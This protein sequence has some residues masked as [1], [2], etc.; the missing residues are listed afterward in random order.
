MSEIGELLAAALADPARRRELGGELRKLNRMWVEYDDAVA[1]FVL[2]ADAEP[3]ELCVLLV[4]LNWRPSLFGEAV[5]AA[6]GVDARQ[7]AVLEAVVAAFPDEPRVGAAIGEA[8]LRDEEGFRTVAPEE[9]AA[10][11]VSEAAS[12]RAVPDAEVLA[13]FDHNSV[14]TFLDTS[15]I[16]FYLPAAIACALRHPASNCES[17][18]CM[19]LVDWATKGKTGAWSPAQRAAIAAF[20]AYVADDVPAY[21]R[22]RK[23][24]GQAALALWSAATARS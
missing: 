23:P 18:T 1:S 4:D 24:E 9:Y 5:R 6:L 21:G 3:R 12:W 17:Y 16:A 11:R 2:T 8:Y 13:A 10:A 14:F 7:S 19:A 22:L 15:A 20:L